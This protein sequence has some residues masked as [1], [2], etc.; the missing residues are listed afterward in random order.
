MRDQKE[1]NS[2]IVDFEESDL[3][4]A[5]EMP[6][7]ARKYTNK[8]GKID[9]FEIREG[10]TPDGISYYLRVYTE[11]LGKEK[12]KDKQT[13][14]EET[15]EIRA[16]R[17]FGLIKDEN[18]KF[19]WGSKSKLATFLNKHTLKHFKDIKGTKVLSTIEMKGEQEYL[20]FI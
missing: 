19:S 11:P 15:I 7:F 3:G 12:I 6:S 1:S 18:S 8:S 5:I 2:K 16:S 14:L 9:G 13:G 17:N 4:G 10:K 20:S